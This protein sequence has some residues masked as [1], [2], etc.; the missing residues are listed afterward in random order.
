MKAWL[1]KSQPFFGR[2]SREQVGEMEA[3]YDYTLS[4]G[5][6][7]R[8]LLSL[9]GVFLL[10]VGL[11]LITGGVAYYGYANKARADLSQVSVSPAL[12]GPIAPEPLV[13]PPAAPQPASSVAVLPGISGSAV[14]SLGYGGGASLASSWPAPLAHSTESRDFLIELRDFTPLDAGQA[15][16]VGSQPG[17]ARIILPT[18]GIDSV[19]EELGILGQ[20]DN[21]AYETP[22]NIVGHIPDSANAGEAGSSW[23]FGHLESPILGQGSVFYELLQVPEMLGQGQEVHVITDNGSHQYLYRITSTEVVHQDELS[24]KDAGIASIHLVACVPALVYD[25]RLIVTGE[26]AGYH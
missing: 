5:R 10:V 6:I 22:A 21:R 18:L 4:R 26:L 15:H 2:L 25:H 1:R 14:D 8:K 12:T 19:V 11:L 24:L 23:Y 16:P 13:S 7:R 17:V 3:G 20:G 9:P